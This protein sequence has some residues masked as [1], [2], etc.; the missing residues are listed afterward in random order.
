MPMAARQTARKQLQSRAAAGPA[1]L[2]PAIHGKQPL[3]A[4]SHTAASIA[5]KT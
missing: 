5:E 4:L 3:T 2:S 1:G